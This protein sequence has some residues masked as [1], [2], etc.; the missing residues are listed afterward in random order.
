M[1]RFSQ[2][3]IEMIPL[4]QPH[5]NAKFEDGTLEYVNV[6]G[7]EGGAITEVAFLSYATPRAPDDAMAEPLR[8][9]GIEVHLVG[10]CLSPQEL[11]AATADGHAVGNAL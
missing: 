3:K 8:A 5:W 4:A 1:R 11:L 7:G 10:D 2:Q 9:V 6:Y